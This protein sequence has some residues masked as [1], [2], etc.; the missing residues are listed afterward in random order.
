M[1]LFIE[2]SET[3]SYYIK[4]NY[5]VSFFFIRPPL[6]TPITHTKKPRKLKPLIMKSKKRKKKKTAEMTSLCNNKIEGP[7]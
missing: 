1:L 2:A 5:F 6:I 7:F 4:D 3:D